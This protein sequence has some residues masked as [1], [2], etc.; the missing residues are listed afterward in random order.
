ML[1]ENAKLRQNNEIW[2]C[3]VIVSMH[4]LQICAGKGSPQEARQRPKRRNQRLRRQCFL[5][6]FLKKIEHMCELLDK[7]RTR[8]LQQ[9]E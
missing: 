8:G 2:R 6:M 4:G 1:Y 7:V 9:Q 3:A 5:C